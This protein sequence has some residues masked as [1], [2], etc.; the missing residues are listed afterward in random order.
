V[1]SLSCTLG[2]VYIPEKHR[3]MQSL[4][5]EQ[6]IKQC[7]RDSITGP[8]MMKL[9]DCDTDTKRNSINSD[10][11]ETEQVTCKEQSV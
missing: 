6:Y 11:E 5:E 8:I 2:S 1:A 10:Y 7:A 4:T 3:D 9:W